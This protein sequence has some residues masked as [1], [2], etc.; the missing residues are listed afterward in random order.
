LSFRAKSETE[1]Q[2][3]PWRETWPE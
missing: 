2:A 1:P 3:S